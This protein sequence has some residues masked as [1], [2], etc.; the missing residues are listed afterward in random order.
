MLQSVVDNLAP[1]RP[2]GPAKQAGYTPRVFAFERPAKK[3]RPGGPAESTPPGESGTPGGSAP[4]GRAGDNRF[5]RPITGMIPKLKPLTG[6]IARV[7][8][9]QA[10]RHPHGPATPPPGAVPPGGAVPPA[11]AVPPP[12]P[13]PPGGP[14][15]G[16]GPVQPGAPIPPGGPHPTAGPVPPAGVAHP[17]DPAHPAGTIPAA[18]AGASDTPQG[19]PGA[20]AGGVP[21]AAVPL[22]NVA[23]PGGPGASGGPAKPGESPRPGEL[24]GSAWPPAPGGPDGTGQF[25]PPPPGGS[26]TFGIQEDSTPHRGRRIALGVG[27]G[28]VALCGLFAVIAGVQ[29]G[30]VP[31]GVR[32]AGVEIGGQSRDEA[33]ATLD[34]ALAPRAKE[35]VALVAGTAES[36]L[37]PAKAGLAYDAEA[38]VDALTGF[39][40]DPARMWEHFFGADEAELVL[41]V[42]EEKLGSAVEGLEESMTVKPADGAVTFKDGAPQAT[43]AKQGSRVDAA[44]AQAVITSS[45]LRTEPPYTL[46]TQEVAPEITQDE[47]DAAMDT[48]SKVVSA[49]VSVEVGG[50]SVELT[51]ADLATFAS[52]EPSDGDLALRF[53]REGL[54]NAVVERTANLLTIPEDAHFVFQDGKPQV[55]GGGPGTTL[56]PKEVGEAVNVAARGDDRVAA[57]EL[58]EQDPEN[59]KE[60]LED[61]GVKEIVSEFSTP[62]TADNVRTQNLIR[63]AEM[64]TGELVKPGETFSLIEALSPITEANG[65]VSS[66]IVSNGQHVEGVGGGLS[67]MATTSYNAGYFAGFD[68]VEHRQHSFWFPRYPAGREATIYVGALDMRFKNDTPYG[69]VLQSFV[70]NGQLTVRIW[71]TKYY[72][73][74]TSDSGHQNVVETSTVKSNDPECVDYPGGE[75]GFTISNYRKVL[76]NG[77]VVKDETYTWTYK[78]DN[79]V[80]CTRGGGNGGGGGN[81]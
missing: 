60:A 16:A 35:P 68:D 46:P 65:Y 43:D 30:A 52:F 51:P 81:G 56:K 44:G 47:V 59:T 25:P 64:V 45:W 11:G 38:T 3:S 61:L 5:M 10:A 15:P 39:S 17:G 54:V 55:V 13:V 40:L 80:E 24:I 23:A 19:S 79:P 62:L 72:E 74:Q 37:K 70:S 20:P 63:G 49:P 8:N 33:I 7:V 34:E 78:P 53:D 28:V 67:Q 58:H 2:A 1:E 66:G 27:L 48:A 31:N 76:L 12:G 41:A 69:A 22:G 77:E 14:V 42:D 9:P 29:A 50:Q 4:A 6:A 57:V 32:V 75:D 36:K 73:V 71:S 26:W 18:A 21:P